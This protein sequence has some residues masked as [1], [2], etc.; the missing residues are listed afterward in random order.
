MAQKS[1]R[2]ISSHSLSTQN[3]DSQSTMVELSV[4]TVIKKQKPMDQNN[5]E[6]VV[7]KRQVSTLEN[8][9]QAVTIGTQDEYAAAADLVAKL[10]ETGSQIKAK[11]ESLTKPA[12]EILKNARDLFRPIEEQFANAEA[13]IKTKLLGYKRKVDEEARI[14]E[15]K[16][17]KQAESGHIKIETAE[18]KMDAIERVDTTTRGKIGEVQIRKIKKVRITDEAAL[19]REY[20]IPD[21]VAIRRDALGGKT[22]PG[23]EVYEEEQVAAGRF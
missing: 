8:Q 11:K 3:F 13:I 6:L 22:I 12:N 15:A 2:I 4:M 9:A 1:K 19:P 23:V 17:A 5:K 16:I 18:R 7:L 20:L 21:N 14:A 10:K